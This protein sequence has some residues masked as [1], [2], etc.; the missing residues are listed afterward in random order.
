MITQ[1]DILRRPILSEKSVGLKEEGR[2]ICLEVL[3]KA[4][5]QQIKSAAE[6][7]FGVKVEAV[8]TSIYRGKTKRMGKSM[9]KT[10]NWKKAVLTLSADSDVDAFGIFQQVA[11]AEGQN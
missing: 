3:P 9:G 1:Y 2:Q 8:N 10:S 4:N 5:K 7:L 11:P 6:K